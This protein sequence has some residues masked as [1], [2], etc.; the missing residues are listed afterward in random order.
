MKKV[1]DGVGVVKE[2]IGGQSFPGDHV[3]LFADSPFEI[4]EIWVIDHQD[5]LRYQQVE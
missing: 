3:G 5:H 1:D 2:I 4:L